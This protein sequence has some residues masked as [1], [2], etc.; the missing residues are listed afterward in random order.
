MQEAAEN[1]KAD[2]RQRRLVE[3]LSTYQCRPA[4]RG[5][6][7]PCIRRYAESAMGLLSDVAP[8]R[9]KCSINQGGALK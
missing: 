1:L 8:S 7:Y 9:I 6:A 4:R 2:E 5:G 3:P